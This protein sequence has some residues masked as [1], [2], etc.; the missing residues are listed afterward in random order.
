MITTRLWPLDMG[1][2]HMYQVSWTV[3]RYGIS[4]ICANVHAHVHLRSHVYC[5]SLLVMNDRR[6]LTMQFT[7]T[8]Q[9]II[10]ITGM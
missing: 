10:T 6:A 8:A 2:I 9:T 5:S 4:C 3:I 7:S 1:Y